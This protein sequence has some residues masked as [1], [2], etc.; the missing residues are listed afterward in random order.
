[1]SMIGNVEKRAGHKVASSIYFTRLNASLHPASFFR[2]LKVPLFREISRVQQHAKG[3][4]RGP[5]IPK[6]C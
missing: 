6:Q 5:A 3:G 4:H 1:M 2:E